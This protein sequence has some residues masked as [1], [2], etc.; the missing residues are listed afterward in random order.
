MHST[1]ST[2]SEYLMEQVP[3]TSYSEPK[4]ITS[5]SGQ[6]PISPQ[7]GQ[8][9]N[10]AISNPKTNWLLDLEWAI[11]GKS[12]EITKE[13]SY[14]MQFMRSIH[15][16]H[17]KNVEKILHAFIIFDKVK[18]LVQWLPEAEG[19]KA[20]GY[21]VDAEIAALLW[22]DPVKQFLQNASDQQVITLA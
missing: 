9:S 13:S 1:K 22:P 8:N 6:K 21:A 18:Y 19:E 20:N 7:S 14:S 2:P 10:T 16:K 4:P 3:S 12:M 11:P 15:K 5:Q 17:Q